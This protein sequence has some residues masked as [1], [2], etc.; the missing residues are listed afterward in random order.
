LDD[1]FEIEQI[2]TDRF[3]KFPNP[4]QFSFQYE[5]EGSLRMT[6]HQDLIDH[7]GSCTVFRLGIVSAEFLYSQ[8][9]VLWFCG[10]S[11]PTFDIPYTLKDEGWAIWGQVEQIFRTRAGKLKTLATSLPQDFY[12]GA[13]LVSLVIG[14][15]TGHLL[16]RPDQYGI[17]GLIGFALI[18]VSLQILVSAKTR[19]NQI[20]LH[21]RREREK[22]KEVAR[23][24]WFGKVALLVLGAILGT[25]GT[26]LVD[27]FTHR[28]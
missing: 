25:I 23:R 15:I 12:Y 24:E 5:V 22:S 20:F 16:N 18:I 9:R 27:Y 14:F 10:R 3:S 17:L 26:I 13:G 1:L 4:P 2:L 19:N 7:G 28:H 11:K 21:Y 6:T 8:D